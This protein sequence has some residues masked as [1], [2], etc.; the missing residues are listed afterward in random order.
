MTS[1]HHYINQGTDL[2][3]TLEQLKSLLAAHRD[4]AA[5]LLVAADAEGADGVAGL[6]EHGGLARQ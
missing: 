2:E 3:A 1:H 4:E 5:D 6:G